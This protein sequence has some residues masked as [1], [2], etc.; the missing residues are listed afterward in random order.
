M[1]LST[2]INIFSMKINS[3]SNNGSVNIGESFHNSHTANS[4]TTGE[5]SSYGDH[6]PPTA[7]MKNI[8]IDPDVNDQNEVGNVDNVNANQI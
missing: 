6:A 5:N 8:Y 3:I 7:T 2:V 4:K 1:P